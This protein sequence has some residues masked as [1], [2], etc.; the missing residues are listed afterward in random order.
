VTE[1]PEFYP[2]PSFPV[3]AVS[4]VQKSSAWYQEVLG[5]A[6]VFTMPGPGGTAALAHLRWAK[7]ADLLLRMS[8]PLEG[9]RGIGIA[10]NYAL[11]GRT[12]DAVDMLA[13]RARRHGAVIINEPG[14]RPWNARDFTVADPDGYALTF[15][16]GPLKQ[17]LSMDEVTGKVA[18]S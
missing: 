3:L 13:E 12:I 9:K 14:D 15:T 8:P 6:H 18:R 16:F 2:M 17:N 5:F 7:Y 11:L 1:Q 4:D 10:L